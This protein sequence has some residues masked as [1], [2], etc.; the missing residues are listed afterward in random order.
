MDEQATLQLVPALRAPR[1]ARA[2]VAETLTAWDVQGDAVEATKLVVSELVTNAVLHSPES[3]TISLDLRLNDGAVRVLVTDGGLAEPKRRA[4]PDS[5]TA[6]SGRGVRLV[7][8][9]TEQWGTETHGVDGKTVWCELGADGPT[10][11]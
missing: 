3:A 7:E 6:E 9:F 5:S 11:R 8:A 2:F 1:A 10:T 4:P